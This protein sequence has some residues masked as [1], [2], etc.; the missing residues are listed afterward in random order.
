MNA[1]DGDFAHDQLPFFAYVQAQEL[2]FRKGGLG[3]VGFQQHRGM[4][5]WHIFGSLLEGA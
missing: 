5:V 1:S 2:R 4:G 3:D